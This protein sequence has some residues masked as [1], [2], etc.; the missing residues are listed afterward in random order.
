MAPENLTAYGS[1]L[2]AEQQ[3]L[4]NQ[5]RRPPR[6]MPV[7]VLADISGSMDGEKI[8]VLN[9]SI[10]SMLHAFAAEDS[11]RGEIHVAVI[12]FGGD[13]AVVHQPLVRASQAQWTEL[14]PRGRTPMG[15]A[16]DLTRALLD[17]PTIVP[18]RAFPPTLVL[19][20][21]GLPTDDWQAPLTALLGTRW[22]ARALRLAIGIGVD[23]TS[24]AD[25]VLAQFSTPG[26]DVLR[27][28]QV[29]EIPAQFRW[30]TATVTEQLHQ[31]T[32]ARAVR[33]EDLD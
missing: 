11:A 6:P 30:V 10:R 32:A 18:K 1:T 33:L 24:E 9:R 27:S 12:A 29:H 15:G 21:D 26:T 14:T 17:D 3:V 16:F 25:E 22:G 4:A 5:S 13:E 28:D 2:D 20:S 23:R 31:R 19:V 8:H 7:I